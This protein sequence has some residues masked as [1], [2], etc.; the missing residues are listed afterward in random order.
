VNLNHKKKKYIY[1]IFLFIISISFF[2]FKKEDNLIKKDLK[3][4]LKKYKIQTNIFLDRNYINE[5]NNKFLDNKYIIQIPRHYKKNIQI[6]HSGNIILYRVLCT[7]NDN[8]YNE[9]KIL[10]IE[11]FIPGISCIHKKV[12]KKEFNSGLYIIKPGGPIS[13]DP[14]F[15]EKLEDQNIVILNE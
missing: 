11:L 12:I 7:K 5:K 3:L 10:D 4:S 1:I 9:W 6:Q 8:E 14:I 2:L 13:S 15:L